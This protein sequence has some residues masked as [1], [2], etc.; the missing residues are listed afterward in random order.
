MT[1]SVQTS[2]RAVAGVGFK[3]AV[4]RILFHDLRTMPR[5]FAAEYDQIEQRVGSQAVRAVHRYTGRFAHRH[6]SRNDRLAPAHA[7]DHLTMHVARDTAH[8]VVHRGQYGYGVLVDVDSGEYS[9]GLG[10]TRQSLLDDCGTQV[11]QMQ[12]DMVLERT[13][14]APLANL[15]GHRAADD[16]ARR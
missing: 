12:I 6:E 3:C 2:Q 9:R 15:D 7:R 5:R 11:L 16:V 1:Q 4:R 13:D 14:A 10:D 8:V